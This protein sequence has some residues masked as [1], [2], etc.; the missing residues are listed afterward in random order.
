MSIAIVG[1]SGRTGTA[2]LTAAAARGIATVAVVRNAARLSAPSTSIAIADAADPA[3]LAAAFADADAVIW[4]VGPVKGEP[5]GVMAR[6]IPA[7]LAAMREASVDRL[8]VVSASGP[9][10]EG[11]SWLLARVIKPIVTLFLGGAFRDIAAT[12]AIV[13]ASDTRWTLVR[14]PQLTDAPARGY[15]AARGRNVSGGFRVTRADLAA[16]LLDALEDPTS[17][18]G[19][20]SIAN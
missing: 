17:E 8:L 20:I 12:D 19:I 13:Q 5:E 4:C 15:R 1:A 3:A 6:T 14:P 11:D 16:A 18:R 2:V 9:F 7:T 10:T